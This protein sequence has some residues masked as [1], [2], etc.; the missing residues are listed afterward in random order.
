MEEHVQKTNKYMRLCS[1]SL[2]TKE[3]QTK[4]MIRYHYR[5]VRMTEKSDMVTVPEASEHRGAGSCVH[6]WRNGK[7]AESI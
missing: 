4:P 2:A 3:M 5:P 7:M 1:M 6:F